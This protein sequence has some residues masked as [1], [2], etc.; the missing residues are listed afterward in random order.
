MFCRNN[1]GGHH[2][3]AG[4]TR[5]HIISYCVVS[6]ESR[7]DFQK[8]F[9]EVLRSIRDEAKRIRQGYLHSAFYISPTFACNDER[10]RHI[11]RW[12]ITML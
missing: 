12:P 10:P 9:L 2:N 1:L 5:Y 3:T 6:Y 11:K 7:N 4:S 8:H